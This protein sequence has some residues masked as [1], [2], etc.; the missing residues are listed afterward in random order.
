MRLGARL[1]AVIQNLMHRQKVEAELEAEIRAY[2]DGVAGERIAAGMSAEEARRTALAEC[3]GAEQVKQAVRDRRAGAGIEVLGQDVRFA[4]RLLR[5]SPGFTAVVVLTLAL[6][7]GANT[8]IFSWVNAV[9]LQSLPVRDAQ[10]LVVARWTAHQW[11]HQVGTSSYGDC[12]AHQSKEGGNVN[13]C[14]VSEAMFREMESRTDLFSGAT[15]FAGTAGLVVSGNGEASVAQGL[16][17]SGRYFA[18][19]GV[20]AAVGRTLVADDDRPGAAAV[21]VLDYGYWQ[22]A[23]GGLPSAVGKTVRL[24]NVVFTIVGVADRGFTRLTPGKS[25]DLWVP[26]TQAVPLGIS[27]G[28]KPGAD[29]V[30]LWLTVLARLKPGVARRQ[31]AAAVTTL[32]RNETLHGATPMWKEADDPEMT[33][34]PAQEGLVGFRE[35]LEVPLLLMMA[36]VG[37]V[38][39][40]ACANVAGLML[41]RS[42]VREK[43][44]AVRLALGASRRRVMQQM[45]TES[46]LLSVAGAALGVVLAYGGAR[47]LVAFVAANSNSPLRV[48]V[49]P[50]AMVLLFTALVA[51]LTGIGFGLAPAWRGARTR[52]AAEFN[53][54]NAGS[55]LP[56]AH[57]SRWR[58]GL[59]NTLVVT[60]VA[61]SMVVL[62]GAGL[63]LR[64]LEKLR[65]VNPGFDT[66]NVLLFDIDPS[67]AGYKA[68]GVGPLYKNLQSR[69]QALP[70]VLSASYASDALLDGSLWTQDV[71]VEGQSGKD[72]VETQML[73]V[74]S[75]YFATMRIPLLRGRG[76]GAAE[77]RPGQTLAVVNEAFVR[78]FVGARNPMGLH[79]GGTDT[80]DPQ[81]EIAGIVGDT[82]YEGLRAE[83]GPTAYVPMEKG[84]ATFAVRTAGA[85]AALIPAVRKMVRD[86][87]ANVP[88]LRVVTQAQ[89]IDRLLLNERLVARLFGLFAGLAL[90]LASIGLYGLL[91][92]EVAGRT[93]E[94]GIRTALGAQR[95]SV[96]L[97]FLRRGLVLVV[98]GSVAGVAAA[99]LVSR[100]LESL[101]FGVGPT[102]PATFAA[103][104]VLLVAVGVA[105][106]WIP[107]MR[108]TRVDPAVALRCE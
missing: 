57:G 23:F 81:W 47:A 80:K 79:F 52:V 21:A 9:L 66:R 67:L 78:K 6:G 97:L 15:A 38:L 96:L 102:D 83:D 27:W 4:L 22:T 54:G 30:S 19:L 103:V 85:P 16:L 26:Y 107:A 99:I 3:G 88:I 2:V 73:S 32:F 74:G 91:S 87:D 42:G 100:L 59:G 49:R 84:E 36:A 89:T 18:T 40:I 75:D 29:H 68:D 86:V 90:M 31:A 20:P 14:S 50:D 53:K 106:C 58:L 25:V 60:Q 95:R 108:A 63:L 10:Q 33:L 43:E 72:T 56:A 64:T 11:P 77:V 7:I 62:T 94:I 24:N 70:G 51:L 1:R 48:D 28:G 82:K 5:K 41:A 93:R 39:L 76:L 98:V 8:A 71:K 12:G 92:Y 101:L 44:M 37:I 45:L 55:A 61:L 17:V 34:V 46:L 69:L 104:P 13:G 35:E 105:A 65:S